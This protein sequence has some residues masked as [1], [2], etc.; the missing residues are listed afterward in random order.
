MSLRSVKL[1]FYKGE[2]GFTDKVVRWWTSSPYSHVEIVVGDEWYSS[3]PMDGGVRVKTITSPNP[4]SWDYVDVRVDMDRLL[5]VFNKHKGKGYDWVGI[6]FSQW[7][8][9]GFDSKDKC[10]CSEFCAEV[11]WFSDTNIDQQTLYDMVS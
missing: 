6:L 5:Y 9:L 11:L 1:A 3:S 2:G 7:L 10:Y 8:P 4:G